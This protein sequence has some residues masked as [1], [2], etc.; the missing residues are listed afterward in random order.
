MTTTNAGQAGYYN[1]VVDPGTYVVMFMAPAGTAL[2]P[3]GAPG[4][5]AGTDSD[6]NPIT[7][8]SAPVTVGS[9][10]TNT[11]IDAGLYQPASLGNYVWFDEDKDGVQ[12]AN[13]VGI[14]GF[15]VNL[16]NAA[17]VLQSSTT[18]I[19]NPNDGSHGY[20]QFTNLAPGAYY[21]QIVPTAGLG[22]TSTIPN[23]QPLA[24]EATDSDVSGLHGANTTS[25]VTLVSGQNYPDLD[26]GFYLNNAIGNFVWNDIDRDGIQD[27]GE[28][29]INGITVTLYSSTGVIVEQMITANAPG[30][31]QAGWYQFDNLLPGNYYVKFDVPTGYYAT[32]PNTTG[33][34]ADS[35]LTGTNGTGTTAMINVT[36]GSINNDVDA[37]L[38]RAVKIGN[39]VWNDTGADNLGQSLEAFNGIQDPGELPQTNLTVTLKNLAGITI[40]TTTTDSKGEYC[41]FVEPNSGSYYVEFALPLGFGFTSANVLGNTMDAFDSDVTKTFGEGTTAAFAVGTIDNMTIDAGIYLLVLPLELLEFEAEYVNKN[42]N[43]TWSTT[44]EVNSDKFIIERRHELESKFTEIGNVKANNVAS[45]IN[46][47]SF[48]DQTIVKDGRYYYR[49]KVLDN[50][51]RFTYS[52][53]RTVEVN[54]GSTIDIIA[55]PNPVSDILYVQISGSK[56]NDVKYEIVD[57]FGRVYLSQSETLSSNNTLQNIKIDVSNFKSGT[58]FLRM[59]MKNKTL[60]EKITITH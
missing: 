5:T 28:A 52:N 15:V 58:Y 21:V 53:V 2:S 51:R 43:L 27:A 50:N 18:T 14:D 1:F 24:T 17:G 47:Y 16:Y 46:E 57:L 26:A 37:G 8:N 39:F 48:V 44:N 22:Y 13:E 40:Q 19:Q 32:L 35:D 4:S 38:Y 10:S 36:A 31:G 30:T 59:N 55:M 3:T 20:Y 42:A 49:L 9:G 25:D 6:P 12:D 60:T 41:F 29:G 7:G 56:L 23:N 33:E 11:T 54:T 34:A 45:A